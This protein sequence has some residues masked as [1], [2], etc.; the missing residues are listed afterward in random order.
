MV[1]H[2]DAKLLG[3]A[4]VLGGYLDRTDPGQFVATRG[5]RRIGV[6]QDDQRGS[7][8]NIE[9]MPGCT[10]PGKI[11]SYHNS[12]SVAKVVYVRINNFFS[13]Y[14]NY[15]NCLSLSLFIVKLL[16]TLTI[17]GATCSPRKCG[18]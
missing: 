17:R 5:Q 4:S 7:E 3:V 14:L 18:D 13:K 9:L 1:A 8:Q 2:L 15:R 16:N 6:Q 10:E 11:C 12:Y